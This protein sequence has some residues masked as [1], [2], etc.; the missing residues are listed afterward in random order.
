MNSRSEDGARSD[1]WLIGPATE[2]EDS[3]TR[4]MQSTEAPE[5]DP[6]ETRDHLETTFLRYLRTLHPLRS[7]PLR[8]AYW[9]EVG[10][11]G[12]MLK[13]P[14]LEAASPFRTGA[15]L[16]DLVADG[17]LSG[18]FRNLDSPALPLSRSLYEHQVTAIRKLVERKR[19]VVIATGT[20]SG[21]TESFM[22]PIINSL[23]TEHE[24]GTLS[25]PGVRALLLY[26]M[27]ALAN[28][29]IKRLRELLKHSPEI[30][31]GRYTGETDHKRQYAIERFRKH[32]YGEDPLPNELLSREEMQDHPPHIL[33]TNYAMLE[34]LLLRPTD[35]SL[36][37][38]D[39]GKHWKHVVLD[40]AHT[41]NG[42]TGIEVAMLLRRVKD[43]V[44][45]SEPGRLQCI[46]TSATLGRGAND[47]PAVAEFASNLFGEPFEWGDDLD[48][49]DV[50]EAARSSVLP[51]AVD[52][53][54]LPF[55]PSLYAELRACL[56]DRDPR[57]SMNACAH[58]YQL[59]HRWMG[60]A[61]RAS[62]DV[63]EESAASIWLASLLCHDENLR[64]LHQLMSQGPQELR[65]AAEA[66]FPHDSN[67]KS[68]E[69]VDL[70]ALATRARL[71]P[72]ASALLPAR[73]HVF[74][75]ALEGAFVCFGDHDGS[76]PKLYLAAH[77]Y[78]PECSARGA[79]RSVF[80]LASCNNCGAEYVTGQIESDSGDSARRIVPHSPGSGSS[81]R[82][83]YLGEDVAVI[84]EDSVASDGEVA[85]TD[86]DSPAQEQETPARLCMLCGAIAEGVGGKPECEHA[87]REGAIRHVTLMDNRFSAFG[88][89]RAC[90]ACGTRGQRT[91]VNRFTTGQDAPVSVLGTHLYEKIPE[92]RSPEL[93]TKPGGGRKL[94]VFADSRQ[95]AAFFAPYLDRNHHQLLRR[96]LVVKVLQD[97]LTG[98]APPRIHD[99]CSWLIPEAQEAG[100][101][102]SKQSALEQ[103]HEV[104]RWIMAEFTSWDRRNSAEGSGLIRFT[105]AFADSHQHDLE[106][107]VPPPL[108]REP[109]NLARGEAVELIILLL[110]TLRH[111]GAVTYPDGV[112]P[113]D[114]IFEPRNR[115]IFVRNEGSGRGILSWYPMTNT[116]RRLDVLERVIARTSPNLSEAKRTEAARN[117]LDG[118]WRLLTGSD[119]W[120]SCF[121]QESV[122]KEGTLHRLDYQMWNVE[123]AGEQQSR[124]RSYRCN[125]CRVISHRNVR[126]VCPTMKCPGTLEELD[127]TDPSVT[128][129]NYRQV[130]QTLA[131]ISLSAQE[132]TAQWNSDKAAEIQQEFMRGDVN[133]LSCSTTFE[134]GVDVGELQAVLLRNVPPSTANYIQRAGRAGRRSDSTAFVV[135]YAQRRPHDLTFY[136][137]P[138]E[139]VAGRISP[140]RVSLDNVKIIRRHA[141]S[142]A[143][144]SF[145]RHDEAGQRFSFPLKVGSFYKPEDSEKLRGPFCLEAYLLTRPGRVRNALARIMPKRAAQEIGIDNWD[146]VEHLVGSEQGV[147]NRAAEILQEDV[148]LLNNLAQEA[149]HN[150]QGAIHDRYERIKQTILGRDLLGNLGNN[151][152]LPKYSFPSD[153]V[154]LKTNHIPQEAARNVTLA[155]DVR[156]ALS[157]YAPGSE[158]VA[159]GYVWQ[160]GGIVR[161]YERGWDTWHY[162]VCAT[163]MS[164]SRQRDQQPQ[165]CSVCGETMSA[166]DGMSGT[167][168]VPEFGFLAA[169]ESTKRS[170]ETRPG[171][172]YASRV[173]FTQDDSSVDAPV[174]EDPEDG[175]TREINGGVRAHYSRRGNLSVVNSGRFGRGFRT[176]ERCGY[177][178]PAPIPQGAKSR[179]NSRLERPKHKNPRTGREC[180]GYLSRYHLGYT[181]ESDVLGV[182]FPFF[183]DRDT[184]LSLLYA[185]LE[186]GS[187][188]LGIERNDLDG[189]L[190]GIGRQQQRIVLF[191]S[192]PGGAGHV[193]RF[194]DELETVLQASNTLVTTCSC[195]EETSCYNCLR[196]YSNQ[197]FHQNLSRGKAAAV[198]LQV[199]GVPRYTL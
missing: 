117:A 108:R 82:Y 27:N 131:P 101:L 128:E 23:L 84:D 89:L 73:Y 193:R 197:F 17:V 138:E 194:A 136:R 153:V 94:L 169:S 21:K 13:G 171:R 163:C 199:F 107:M 52:R 156:Q 196:S 60:E 113:T 64:K 164:F 53:Q 137:S 76:G 176:C 100:M 42:A 48:R 159:G 189:T 155:R 18:Q 9:R 30:T 47:Y 167:Y 45:R 62:S 36:F 93:S 29:Q 59:D 79:S 115:E 65:K 41:Y 99:I 95:D 121:Q 190:Y 191:D 126:S 46:A 112:L 135:T 63:A 90:A 102:S 133:V 1:E 72:E 175:F 110:D 179:R 147:L 61:D 116:N 39:T 70:V 12:A 2:A 25:Q 92:A 86:V 180:T 98:D 170:G 188:A 173:F 69:L 22:V 15:S 28:D 160:S 26:P 165:V 96:R 187:R 4:K 143:I 32:F 124:I 120:K 97:R 71:D 123:F 66:V 142:V 34:Y 51:Y 33:L 140:P 129:N 152:V 67:A 178:E 19:N 80:E 78:C 150:R 109:W 166:L 49:R 6:I 37:D 186:A 103:R 144:A 149:L 151:N 3:R 16:E 31:F 130:Y 54:A 56:D 146:W 75:R 158:V 119:P 182:E 118:L 114:E 77:E 14:I 74:V 157:D 88:G 104:L 20:G 83:F 181:F 141:H 139:M 172:I 168:I 198:L 145:F 132:H 195:G 105:P 40:E 5:I 57:E 58:K 43:R 50:V 24:A 162:A 184:A 177:S 185:I 8:D 10:K 7:E 106:Q 125:R 111:N 81:E 183:T 11:P 38:G 161:H 85:S 35:S 192:V 148:D 87:E 127:P 154:E 122:A 91:I 174:P 134:L 44:V 68:S 55:P